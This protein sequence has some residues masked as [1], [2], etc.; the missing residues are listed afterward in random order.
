MRD[1]L[2][3]AAYESRRRAGR[4]KHDG[5]ATARQAP[6]DFRQKIIKRAI[7]HHEQGVTPSGP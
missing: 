5:A 4:S 1:E 7:D 2:I 3:T 6:R